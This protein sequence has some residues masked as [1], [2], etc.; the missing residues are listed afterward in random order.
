MLLSILPFVVAI[1]ATLPPTQSPQSAGDATG[2]P[3]TVV[4]GAAVSLTVELNALD[5]MIDAMGN[6]KT[7]SEDRLAAMAAYMKDQKID[8]GYA[9]FAAAAQVPPVTS[10]LQ[11]YQA[12]LATEKLNGVPKPATSDLGL[13]SREVSA[14]TAQ[15]HAAWDSQNQRFQQVAMTSAYLQSK[16]AFVGYQQWAPT[17]AAAKRNAQIA[18]YK[19]ANDRLNAQQQVC[20]MQIQEMHKEWDQIPH[21]TGL[22]FNYGFSQGNG[23]N[24]GGTGQQANSFGVGTNSP[25]AQGAN[26][27][28]A[29][30]G[31]QGGLYPGAYGAG[32]YNEGGGTPP[33]NDYNVNN[34]ASGYWGGSNY[35][36]YSDNYPDLYGYPAGTQW[37]P[38]GL[39][40][41]GINNVWNRSRT[42]GPPPTPN[43]LRPVGTNSDGSGALNG[44]S[45]GDARS[46]SDRGGK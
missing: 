17:Y 2:S 6:A 9:A 1:S 20:L 15:A 21:G 26:T 8:S 19:A 40:G 30:A 14:S 22:N 31:A 5:A 34:T 46:G 3:T 29:Y 10:F 43:G 44:A 45:V 23:P 11:G 38:G 12:S 18:R 24:E 25:S 27:P 41:S 28:W 32:A 36:S 33:G 4:S 42:G 37:G 35:N 13:L 39:N 16:G 7:N